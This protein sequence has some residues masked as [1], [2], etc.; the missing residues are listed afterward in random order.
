MLIFPLGLI[1][2]GLL[3]YGIASKKRWAVWVGGV[4]LAL[5]VLGAAV[6]RRQKPVS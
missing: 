4:W 6:L 5:N 2:L 1:P 3:V